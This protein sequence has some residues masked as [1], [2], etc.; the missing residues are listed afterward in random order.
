MRIG[1]SVQIL[2]Q[3]ETTT[4]FGFRIAHNINT[5]T[6]LLNTWESVEAQ[7]LPHLKNA[8]HELFFVQ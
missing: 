5:A 4:V 3:T 2:L 8:E 1:F 6:I 7:T